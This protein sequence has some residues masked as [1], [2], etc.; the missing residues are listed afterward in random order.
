[1]KKSSVK[2]IGIEKSFPGVKALKNVNF[3]VFQGEI[4]ALIGENGAGKSTLMNVLMGICKPDHG[5]IFIDNEECSINSP[6]EAVKKGICIV[7]QELNLLPDA[8]V[9]ENIFLGKENK[10]HLGF[11]DWRET[12]KKSQDLL[13]N[14]G[15]K[16]NSKEK[17][18]NLS[19]AYQQLVQVAR[20]LASGAN[21]LIFDEPTAS[22]TKKEIG[23][24]FGIFRQIQS[25]G[26]SI[27]FITHHLDEVKEIAD[28]I[29]IMRDGVI[30]HVGDT[31]DISID[32][33]IL[34][35]ANKEQNIRFQSANRI[36]K[37]NKILS[38]RNFTKENEFLD[39]SFDVYEREIFG[40]GGLIG[41]RRTELINSIFGLSQKTSGEM[42][43]MGNKVEIQSPYD[44]ISLKIGYLPEERRKDGIFPILS[45]NE[46]ISITL[47]RQL[48]SIIGINFSKTKA[49]AEEYISKISIK[50]PSA[51][52]QIK[53][54]SG[55]NQQKAV[56]SRWLAKDVKLLIL[57]EP[58]RGID[59]NAK[60]EIYDLIKKLSC[61]GLTVIIVSSEHEELLSLTDRIMVMHEGINKGIY[62]T[63]DISQEDILMAALK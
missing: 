34:F 52:T 53:N 41:S 24:L 18:M 56:L 30:V 19:V 46:N 60:G 50:T 32:Q 54:L 25:S 17:T 45:L 49:I 27:I 38:V 40:I 63:C 35:M 26:R 22:L 12:E 55:G 36:L 10:N 43:Y 47:Y 33:M 42:Y 21:V 3:E 4:H 1:M 11:I 15:I 57:D 2:M 39:I 6:I 14:L 58:T 23:I 44:A 48:T 13:D 62:K 9:A 61:E 29:T 7:P 20:S 37:D 51:K 16:L 8:S 59:V 5:C 28:K 31:N